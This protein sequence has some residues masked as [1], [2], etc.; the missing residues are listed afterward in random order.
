MP[1][2]IDFLNSRKGAEAQ[3]RELNY[4]LPWRLEVAATQT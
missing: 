2:V 4:Y 1:R 3:R